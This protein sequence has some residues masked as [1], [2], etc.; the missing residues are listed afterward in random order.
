MDSRESVPRGRKRFRLKKWWLGRNDFK[1]LVE[2]AWCTPCEDSNP[3]NVCQSKVRALRRLARGWKANV[4]ADNNR[5]RQ[6]VTAEYTWLDMEVE[7]R[8]LDESEDARMRELAKEL[9]NLWAAEENKVR[10]RCRT[11]IF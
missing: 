10:Q 7:A 11:E 3:V 2:K 1:N 4:I 8:S 6:A 9:E 5:V